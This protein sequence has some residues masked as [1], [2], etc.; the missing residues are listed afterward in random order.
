MKYFEKVACLEFFSN[1]FFTAILS[2]LYGC[3]PNL[4]VEFCQTSRK[5]KRIFCCHLL[6]RAQ[7]KISKL[8]LAF[9]DANF[10]ID[11][12]CSREKIWLPKKARKSFSITRNFPLEPALILVFSVNPESTAAAIVSC[13]W[14]PCYRLLT[15]R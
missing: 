5:L 8:S 4:F 11:G 10:V 12:S 15:S 1:N 3:Q 6:K 2:N 13:L 9:L 7:L 14:L